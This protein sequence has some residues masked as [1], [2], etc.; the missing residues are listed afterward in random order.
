MVSEMR[1]V[2][3]HAAFISS[4]IVLFICV[5]FDEVDAFFNHRIPRACSHLQGKRVG[6]EAEVK[7]VQRRKERK[8]E[9]DAV[10]AGIGLKPVSAAPV[11]SNPVQTDDDTRRPLVKPVSDIDL[12]TQLTYSRNGH[13]VLRNFVDASTLEVIRQELRGVMVTE[14]LR[15]WQQKVQVASN[16]PELASSCR[17][18]EECQRELQALGITA[19]LPFLQYFNTWRTL[20]TVK[21]LAYSL[22]EA[23]TVLLD[24]PSVRLYQDSVFWKRVGDGP[25]P[26]HADARMAPFDTSNFIT[27][28][29]PLQDIPRDGTALLFCSKSHSDFALPYWN[30]VVNDGMADSEWSRLEYRYPK[31]PVSYMPMKLSDLTA[32][33]GFTLHCAD[34]TSSG[35]TDRMALAIS[36]VD[37]RAELRPDALDDV[38]KG[39]NEDKW[40][41]QDWAHSVPPR[42]PFKH[43]LV[44][45]VWPRDE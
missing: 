7:P 26:W 10:V 11:K 32:H 6:K 23:A 25:T 29:V 18:V 39:D 19:S 35:S 28:W 34:G 40:S 22:A 5:C 45:I 27:F 17:T 13:A 21:D 4:V 14:E 38:G 20:A 41:Y 24:V 3:M 30:P 8:K 36:Y 31:K 37:A 16:S 2:G 12:E 9:V 43:D 33:S 1:H 44:P 42:T 15:A